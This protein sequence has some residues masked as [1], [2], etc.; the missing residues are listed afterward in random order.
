MRPAAQQAVGAVLGDT[1]GLPAFLAGS[2]AAAIWYD[3][4]DAYTDVDLF[5]PNPG[6]YFTVVERLRSRGWELDDR[7]EKMLKRHLRY[8]FRG[9]HTNSIKLNQVL[10]GNTESTEV[11]VIYKLVDKHETTNLT[12]V[13]QSFDFGLLGVG[14]ETET[15]NFR[16]LRPYLFPGEDLDGPLPMIE[17]RRESF[18]QGFMSEHI[19]QRTPGRY[20]R[21]VR[22]GYDMSRIKPV[23]EMGYFAYSEYMLDRTKPDKI[24]L[25]KIG[26]KLAEAIR[27]DDFD[28]PD[29]L[30]AFEKAL[31]TFDGLDAILD[32]LE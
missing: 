17:Y 31:P 15:L 28:G 7:N 9:W 18:A 25:G 27:D 5:V 22:Y 24:L 12:D 29:G 6:T 8:G 32:F 23:L 19:M 4:P 10:P 26:L 20:A 2:S 3:K 21:Y 14:Y 11:N 1:A 13:I 16:D 30:L